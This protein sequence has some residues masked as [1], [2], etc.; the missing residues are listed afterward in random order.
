MKVGTLL[1]LAVLAFG[2][3]C[4]PVFAEPPLPAPADCGTCNCSLPVLK[5]CPNDYCRKPMPAIHCPPCGGPD[6]YCRKPYPCI[7]QA[8]WCGCDDYDRKPCPALCRPLCIDYYR[9]VSLC[10]CCSCACQQQWQGALSPDRLEAV[11]G[12]G[13]LSPVPAAGSTTTGMRPTSP[14]HSQ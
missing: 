12:P 7:R 2:L 10:P 5:G 4:A 13:N 8:C 3:W 9:C 11:G 6:D 14:Y 1:P